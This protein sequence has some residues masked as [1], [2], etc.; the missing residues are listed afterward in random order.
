MLIKPL[1]VLNIAKE[2]LINNWEKYCRKNFPII[3][4]NLNDSLINLE[5]I[6]F[7]LLDIDSDYYGNRGLT[8]G[9]TSILKCSSSSNPTSSNLYFGLIYSIF[10]SYY[11]NAGILIESY[12]NEDSLLTELSKEIF[13]DIFQKFLLQFFF[14]MQYEDFE[15]WEYIKNY[16]KFFN[17]DI[18]PFIKNFKIDIS[19]DSNLTENSINLTNPIKEIREDAK[20]ILNKY[21]NFEKNYLPKVKKYLIDIFSFKK[22]ASFNSIFDKY[23][24][25]FKYKEKSIN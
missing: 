8:I 3:K 2:E 14:S 13:E 25:G 10:E 16:V 23:K 5:V 12:I 20:Y 7:D 22:P 21:Q 4:Y 18:I 9:Y 24:N 11:E 19:K 1:D 15:Y 17:F 6:S